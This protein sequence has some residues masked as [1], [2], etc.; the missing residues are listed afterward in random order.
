MSYFHTCPRCGA[1]LDPGEVCDC[2]TAADAANID[3]GGVDPASDQLNESAPIVQGGERK[4][5]YGSSK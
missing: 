5:K 1:H 2:K 4:V 3:G